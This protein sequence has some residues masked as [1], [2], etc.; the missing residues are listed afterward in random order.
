MSQTFEFLETSL[1]IASPD[2]FYQA[3]LETHMGLTDQESEKLNAKLIMIL[4][5]H[6]GDKRVLDEALACARGT[7]K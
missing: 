1:N 7:S 4:A 3:L 6:I 5:N 2:D